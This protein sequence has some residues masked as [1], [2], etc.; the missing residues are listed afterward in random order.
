MKTWFTITNTAATSAAEIDIFDSIGEY[1]VTAKDFSAQLKAIPSG[2]DI[3]VR[4]NS[5][6]GSVFDG[7][8][9][10]NMLAERRDRVTAKIIGVAASMASIVAL[11]AKRVVAASNATI[12]IHNPAAITI[13]E[14]SDM[15]ETADMLDKMRG[16][17]VRA[18]MTKTGKSEQAVEAAMDATT[19]FTAQE[20]KDWGLVDEITGAVQVAAS[21]D[22]SSFQGHSAFKARHLSTEEIWAKQFTNR[23]PARV[24]NREPTASVWARNLAKLGIVGKSSE[25]QPATVPVATRP[26]KTEAPSGR[27]VTE[28]LWAKQFAAKI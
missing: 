8:A 27:R 10:F 19:W 16:P 13:G 25:A 28:A 2:R 9:I 15:R 21:F 3:T 4:I 22:L 20:A 17:L 11:A 5:P 6:G 7:W 1:G 24:G 23:A 26:T 12:M 18:Y 14:S